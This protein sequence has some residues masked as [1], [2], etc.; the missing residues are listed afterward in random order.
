[1]SGAVQA[2]P[3]QVFDTSLGGTVVLTNVLEV[4]PEW[5]GADPDDSTDSG[6]AIRS[7]Y[8]VGRPVRFSTGTYKVVSGNLSLS[9]IGNGLAWIGNGSINTIIH[10]ADSTIKACV[11]RLQS[12]SANWSF[13]GLS[14]K[15]PGKAVGTA[16]KGFYSAYFTGATQNSFSYNL[17][18]HDVSFTDFSG[19]GADVL[20]WFQQFWS[21]CYAINIHGNGITISGDQSPSFSGSGTYNL[22]IDGWAW[23]FEGGDPVISSVNAGN[24]GS[25]AHFGRSPSDLAGPSYC[26][27]VILGMNLEPVLI[28]GTGLLFEVG[29]NIAYG[30]GIQ[31]YANNA[32]VAQGARF[33]GTLNMGMISGNGLQFITVGTGSFTSRLDVV[34][35]GTGGGVLILGNSADA[36]NSAAGK[37]A[38]AGL[39]VYGG[40]LTI[41]DRGLKLAGDFYPTYSM[42]SAFRKVSTDTT[43]YR[44]NGPKGDYILECDASNNDIAVNIDYP[45]YLP[46]RLLI[47][48]RIDSSAYRVRITPSSGGIDNASSYT[49]RALGSVT[50][51]SDGTGWW[52]L[53]SR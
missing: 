16:I 23:W 19:D 27:P 6:P 31:V 8:A 14:F 24:V 29:S 26:F 10:C 7:A 13:T 21:Q 51:F 38:T 46:N 9:S 18:M 47:V 11:E 41:P 2:G 32:V 12:Q 52:V 20:D 5:W 28:G 37:L 43:V 49:L 50:L 35:L 3:K 36:V 40:Y 39:Y 45:S 1:L 34:S 48:K 17:R 30:T 44:D 25:G 42:H 53:G 4:Y 22:N 33:A 15:G